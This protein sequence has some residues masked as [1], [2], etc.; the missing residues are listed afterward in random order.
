MRDWFV[1][2]FRH[3]AAARRSASEGS[4]PEQ[5]LRCLVVRRLQENPESTAL[6]PKRAT[7]GLL[8]GVETQPGLLAVLTPLTPPLSCSWAVILKLGRLNNVARFEVLAL[9]HEACWDRPA[10][11]SRAGR[12]EVTPGARSCTVGDP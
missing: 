5:D 8:S 10:S 9:R 6:L 2:P 11:G 7:C 1:A 3:L 4:Q 12:Q